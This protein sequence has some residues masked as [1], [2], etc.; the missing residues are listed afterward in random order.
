MLRQLFIIKGKIKEIYARYDKFIVPVARFLFAIIT[1]MLINSKLG[2]MARIKSP[3]IAFMLSLIC[4][5]L[6][7]GGIV[8]FSALLI[9]GHVVTL[10]IELGAMVFVAFAVLACVYFRFSPREGYIVALTP[11]LFALRLQYIIPVIAGL[12]LSIFAFIPV[13][14]GIFVYYLIGF[15]KGY[16]LT[17]DE[18]TTTNIMENVKYILNGL[19]NNK[20]MIVYILVFAV[21]IILINVVKK[22]SMDYAWAIASAA[23]TLVNIIMMLVANGVLGAHISVLGIIFGNILGLV[24]AAFMYVM[25]FSGDYSRVENVQFEDDEYYYYV[26]AVPK[27]IVKNNNGVKVK[28]VRENVH[29]ERPVREQYDDYEEL[30]EETEEDEDILEVEEI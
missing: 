4:A 29:K 22:F 7:S 21:T 16:N 24:V 11:V 12:T 17:I 15:C 18:M 13:S 9:L 5:F 20:G 14:I 6:P 28:K 26:K 3:F 30:E 25:V 19:F 1:F 2:Y 8:A 23:G 27:I 10:S